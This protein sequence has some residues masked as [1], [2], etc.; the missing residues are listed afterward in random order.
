MK[1][2]N[3]LVIPSILLLLAVM[4]AGF[5]LYRPYTTNTE[6]ISE[7]A[8]PKM[9]FFITSVNPGKGGDLGGL[10]GADMYCK[11]LAEDAGVTG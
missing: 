1:Q 8:S 6:S 2:K 7:G 11:K 10:P 5:I 9:S 4:T 3:N